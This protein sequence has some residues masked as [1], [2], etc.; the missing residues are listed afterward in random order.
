MHEVSSEGNR[1]SIWRGSLEILVR[2]SIHA[3]VLVDSP[4]YEEASSA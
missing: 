1:L 3:F 4:F 2:V